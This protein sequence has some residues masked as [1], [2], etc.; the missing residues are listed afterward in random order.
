MMKGDHGQ[1]TQLHVYNAIQY[2]LLLLLEHIMCV[3]T[4]VCFA[5]VFVCVR[6]CVCVC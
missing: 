5:C 6:V 3:Y 1:T 4:V 2:V